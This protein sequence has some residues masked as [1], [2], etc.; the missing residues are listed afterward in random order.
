MRISTWDLYQL[1][2]CPK[3]FLESGPRKREDSPARELI[4]KVFLLKA[5]GRERDWTLKGLAPIWDDIFWRGKDFNKSTADDSVRGI[6]AAR[7]LYKSMPKEGFNTYPVSKLKTMVDSSIELS[8]SGDFLL[9]YPDRY[10]TW[11]YF[12]SDPKDI[13]RSILPIV[14]HYLIY[15]RL[16]EKKP[17]YLVCYFISTE[18]LSPIHFRVLDDRTEEECDNIAAY[19]CTQAK[20]KISYPVKG[21]YCKDC[22]L[23]C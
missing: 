21:L 19:L 20:R 17:F 7:K 6:L 4:K 23:D 1:T 3:R 15:K 10:E 2:L 18:R 22:P 9:S 16:K 14:E 12:R 11:L 5:L 13:R 8:S